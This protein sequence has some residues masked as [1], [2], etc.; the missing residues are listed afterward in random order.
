MM[1]AS[2]R[3]DGARVSV[4]SRVELFNTG[5]F[6]TWYNRNYAVHPNGEEFVMVGGTDTQMVWRVNALAGEE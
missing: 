3:Y 4:D 6:Q 5:D 2:V 1:A